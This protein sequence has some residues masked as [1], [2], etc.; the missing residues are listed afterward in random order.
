MQFSYKNELLLFETK[1][2][3]V[4][5]YIQLH[6][7]MLSS[8]ISSNKTGFTD[9]FIFEEGNGLKNHFFQDL[10]SYFPYKRLVLS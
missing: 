1:W 3:F 5:M 6:H 4:Y 2:L 7:G 8:T 9:K 10:T